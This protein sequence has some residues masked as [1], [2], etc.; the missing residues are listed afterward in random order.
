[1]LLCGES[2]LKDLPKALLEELLVG[3]KKIIEG[4]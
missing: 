3:I 1:V 4:K 2:F